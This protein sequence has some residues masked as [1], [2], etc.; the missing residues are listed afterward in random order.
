MQ[1]RVEHA[2][3]LLSHNTDHTKIVIIATLSGF[4]SE[5]SFYRDFRKFTGMKPLEWANQNH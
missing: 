4:S 3:T 2:K 5:Q 1:V